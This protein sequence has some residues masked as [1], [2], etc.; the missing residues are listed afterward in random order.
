VLFNHAGTGVVHA[1]HHEPSIM[2]SAYPITAGPAERIP[3]H[4]LGCAALALD[5]RGRYLAT[6][7]H[8]TVVNLFDTAEWI[9]ARTI[10]GCECVARSFSRDCDPS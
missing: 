1:H 6:G 5:P 9:C 8:D 3:T 4:V 10:T 2:L 7:G